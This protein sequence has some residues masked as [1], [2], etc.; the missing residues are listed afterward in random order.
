MEKILLDFRSTETPAQV[1]EHLAERFHFPGYYGKNLD[2]FYD[3]LTDIT[4]DVCVG[5]FEYEGKRQVD[6]YL[7]R[8]KQVL[9]D[10]QRDNPHIC[11]IFGRLEDNLIL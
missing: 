6:Q 10:A 5:V 9:R 3:C 1:Q 2:A 4:D 8:V 11:V 7:S